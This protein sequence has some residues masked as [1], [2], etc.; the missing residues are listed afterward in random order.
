M[1]CVRERMI[2]IN[3]F[4]GMM[5]VEMRLQKF[6]IKIYNVSETGEESQRIKGL[7]L[8]HQWWIG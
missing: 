4:K 6:W 3:K 7:F 5:E 8:I 2:S 1:Q